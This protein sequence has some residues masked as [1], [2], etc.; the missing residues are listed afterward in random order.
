MSAHRDVALLHSGGVHVMENGMVVGL[1]T[2]AGGKS[3]QPV[4]LLNDLKW[5]SGLE[6]KIV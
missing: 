1:C 2:E 3:D 5:S 4:M 6:N